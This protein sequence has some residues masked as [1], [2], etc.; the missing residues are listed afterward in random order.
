M[1]DFNTRENESGTEPDRQSLKGRLLVGHDALRGAATEL[2]SPRLVLPYLCAALGGAVF[3]AGILMPVYQLARLV[4]NAV[5]APAIARAPNHH[6]FLL[7]SCAMSLLALATIIVVTLLAPSTAMV[8]FAFLFGAFTL[9]VALGVHNIALARAMAYVWKPSNRHKMLSATEI[10]A[11]LSGIVIALVPAFLFE[12]VD[13]LTV[14]VRLLWA[15]AMATVLALLIGVVFARVRV[16]SGAAAMPENASHSVSRPSFFGQ[17]RASYKTLLGF[18]WFRRF[19]LMRLLLVSVQYGAVFY[20]LHA[21]VQHAANPWSLVVFAIAGSLGGMAAGFAS[22]LVP[23]SDPRRSIVL[24]AAAGGAAAFVALSTEFSASVNLAAV[25]ALVF[26]LM[27]AGDVII[28]IGTMAYYLERVDRL[29]LENGLA[30]VKIVLQP[31]ILIQTV[32][33]AYLAH[34]QHVILPVFVLAG[35]AI[36]GLFAAMAL[37]KPGRHDHADPSLMSGSKAHARV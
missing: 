36:A 2:A 8:G 20:A 18:S 26:F 37:P 29:H 14:H 16:G 35:L 9:G 28:Y 22:R 7:L 32:L 1:P 34:F 19:L 33:L 5:F 4:G 15:A 21:A 6:T 10:L 27:S 30:L 17:V 25:Y 23:A 12:T 3:L 31:V 11:G 13:E 24:G